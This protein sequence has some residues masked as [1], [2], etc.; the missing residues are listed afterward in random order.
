M[1]KLELDM[2]FVSNAISTSLQLVLVLVLRLVLAGHLLIEDP[3]FN[4]F[5]RIK[6]IDADGVENERGTISC[7][8]WFIHN[9]FR[10]H[11]INFNSLT[12]IY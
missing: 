11:A 5:V 7:N 9:K 4:F 2:M 3:N 1:Y 12:K 8:M 10:K 6:L